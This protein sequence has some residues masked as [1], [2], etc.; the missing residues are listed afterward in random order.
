MRIDGDPVM[1]MAKRDLI[2]LWDPHSARRI[3]VL[4]GHEGHVRGLCFSP[5]A[6]FLASS[7]LDGRINIWEVFGKPRMPRVPCEAD[8]T[9]TTLSVSPDGNR[10][11]LGK[12]NGEL[13]VLDPQAGRPEKKWKA[14]DT[15]VDYV[16]QAP[17]SSII[18][19][20][21]D[22]S[23]RRWSE[24]GDSL[25]R[26][27]KAY[28]K[29][30]APRPGFAMSPDGRVLATGDSGFDA[31]LW[32][33]D[34]GEKLRS[35]VGHK[36]R[37][38]TLAFSPDGATLVTGSD[39]RTIRLWNLLTGQTRHTIDLPAAAAASVFS[40]NGQLLAVSDNST[41]IGLF[42]VATGTEVRRFGGRRYL[43]SRS[44]VFSPDG[45]FLATADASDT[46]INVWTIPDGRLFQYVDSP[47]EARAVAF[48]PHQR[49]TMAVSI[50]SDLRFLS[51]RSM[52]VLK[53]NPMEMLQQAEQNAGMRVNQFGLVPLDGN[54][55]RG[56][57]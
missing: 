3:E 22:G 20:A 29:K 47:A 21:R 45:A 41:A 49:D 37:V 17:D 53:A 18:S 24:N 19:A 2:E 27:F 1:V 38:V 34:R 46:S 35:F 4:R 8:D 28:D 23:V 11:V 7:G 15:T 36:G 30:V 51:Y 12:K 25:L 52:D 55:M 54:G 16:F 40:P 39:D 10:L 31:H 32:S 48:L 14:H 42:D 43:P 9:T 33:V 57:R 13:S 50:C 44:L 26:E 6:R 56:G 5:D